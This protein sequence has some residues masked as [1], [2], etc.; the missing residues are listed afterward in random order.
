MELRIEDFQLG[1]CK[2]EG[3]FG[4]VFP[5]IHKKSGFLL[6]IKKVAKESIRLMIEQFVQEVKISLFLNH[7]NIVRMYGFFCDSD[8]IY[9]MM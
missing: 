6:A 9:I 4:K 2:G 1:A 3:R 5:A 8:S 7:P